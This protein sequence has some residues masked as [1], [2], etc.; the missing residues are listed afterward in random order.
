M[1]KGFWNNLYGNRVASSIAGLATGTGVAVAA[2]YVANNNFPLVPT[3]V[4]ATTKSVDTI[5]IAWTLPAGGCDGIEIVKTISGVAGST[6]IN[7]ASPGTSYDDTCGNE[8]STTYV[9]R[10]YRAGVYSI[11]SVTVNGSTFCGAPGTIVMDAGY[12]TN[13]TTAVF[14]WTL[15]SDGS[16]GTPPATAYWAIYLGGVLQTTTAIGTTSSSVNIAPYT[17]TSLTLMVRM[18]STYAG[19]T[20]IGPSNSRTLTL[21]H[22]QY[23]GA[24]NTVLGQN[25][26]ASLWRDHSDGVTVGL[27]TGAIAVTVTNLICYPLQN[28]GFSS[29]LFCGTATRKANRIYAGVQQGDMGSCNNPYYENVAVLSNST[30]FWGYIL[31]GT[32]WNT[33]PAAFW[34]NGIVIVWGYWTYGAV[35]NS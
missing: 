31:H 15:V 14:T 2:A 1:S 16:P 24:A 12:P 21:G 9:L 28:Q 26:N 5:Q 22:A 13:H 29:S 23:D 8:K 11:S 32:G 17:N 3:G 4:T 20:G 19:N 27:D 10:S 6:T 33:A 25:N 18:E 34:A 7:V 30:G 35:N